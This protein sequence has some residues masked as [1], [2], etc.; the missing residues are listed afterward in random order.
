MKNVSKFSPLVVVS[1]IMLVVLTSCGGVILKRNEITYQFIRRH[2]IIL[3][4]VL[5][6]G[7]VNEVLT[8]FFANKIL[9][10]FLFLL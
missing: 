2:F 7:L 9:K 3:A 8:Y 1:L 5:G 6:V 4:I 10:L